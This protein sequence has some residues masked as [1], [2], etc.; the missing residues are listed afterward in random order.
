MR[1]AR[2]RAGCRSARASAP[3]PRRRAAAPRPASSAT[4]RSSGSCTR[5]CRR[6]AGRA[7]R[8]ARRR[9]W[10]RSAARQQR[11]AVGDRPRDSNS[12][13]IA[14]RE[15]STGGSHRQRERAARL[16]QQVVVGRRDVRA[17]PAVTGALSMASTTGQRAARAR[18]AAAQP[19]RAGRAAGAGPRAA[20]GANARRQRAQQ[21]RC[22]ASKPPAEAPITM[23]SMSRAGRAWPGHASPLAV[24]ALA[25]RDSASNASACA[26][27]CRL[28]VAAQAEE[29]AART[30]DVAEQ[31]EGAVLQLR[32]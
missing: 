11:V 31:P 4:R 27:N 2:R 32:G 24:D 16:D 22:S 30:S 23:Q 17:C 12:T 10:R 28:S 8:P 6:G 21:M 7:A 5:P 14:G 19:A 9:R 3:R 13:S 20:A 29:A 15:C 25:R 18:A 26:L 1:P